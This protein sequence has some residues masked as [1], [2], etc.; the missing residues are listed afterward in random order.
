MIGVNLHG[1]HSF[2][3]APPQGLGE[4]HIGRHIAFSRIDD[5]DGLFGQIDC[6]RRELP[7]LAAAYDFVRKVCR[8]NLAKRMPKVVEPSI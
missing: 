3:A 5:E 1:R 2:S 4:L 6:K 7:A 8:G